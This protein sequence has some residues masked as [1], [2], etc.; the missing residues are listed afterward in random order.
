MKHNIETSIERQHIYAESQ[1]PT[2]IPHGT[3]EEQQ[4]RGLHLA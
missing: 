4:N 1:V 3:K 2:L